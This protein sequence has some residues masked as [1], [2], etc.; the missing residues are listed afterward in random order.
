MNND[1]Q[2]R[3][4]VIDYWWEKAESSMLSAQRELDAGAYIYSINR[5]YYALFY[6]VSA[7][8]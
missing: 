2:Q 1:E 3:S 7:V 4:K 6:A 8:L 5:L